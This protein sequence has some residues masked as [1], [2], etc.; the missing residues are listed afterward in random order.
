MAWKRGAPPPQSDT[1]RA[2]TTENSQATLSRRRALSLL[3]LSAAAVALPV[4]PIPFRPAEV[5]VPL[6]LL[7]FSLVSLFILL[8]LGKIEKIASDAGEASL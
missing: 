6:R 1:D 8:P 3:T 5:V 7:M 4:P 2:M